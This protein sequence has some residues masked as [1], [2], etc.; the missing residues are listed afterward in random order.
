MKYSLQI[1]NFYDSKFIAMLP[2]L[3]I[4]SGQHRNISMSKKRYC[5]L[6]LYYSHVTPKKT[7]ILN[8]TTI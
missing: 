6:Y 2:G 8:H 5:N 3:K 7:C 1:E 4:Y